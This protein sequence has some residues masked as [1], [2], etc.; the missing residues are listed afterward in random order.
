MKLCNLLLVAFLF[1]SLALS[2]QVEL[3][4]DDPVDPDLAEIV[5]HA[6]NAS[7]VYDIEQSVGPG[8]QTTTFDL[9]AGTWYFAAQACAV[10]RTRCSGYSNEVSTVIEGVPDPLDPP[11]SLRFTGTAAP[12]LLDL[13]FDGSEAMALDGDAIVSGGDLIVSGAGRAI[14][15]SL[16]VSGDQLYIRAVFT[17]MQFGGDFNDDRIVSKAT[18]TSANDHVFML[19]VDTGPNVLRARVRVEGVTTTLVA[20]S[21]ELLAGNTYIG[22]L[23]YDGATLTLRLDGV[24]VGSVPLSGVVDDVDIPVAIGGQPVGAGANYFTGLIHELKIDQVV[25]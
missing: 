20:S 21:G 18:G 3:A 15:G 2:A 22:E 25:P 1:P 10:G 6:G 4:W 13:T 8:V 14:V 23:V 11:T 7:G 17:P 9:G 12:A 16:P 24:E 19:G 5:V